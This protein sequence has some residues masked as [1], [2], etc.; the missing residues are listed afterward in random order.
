MRETPYEAAKRLFQA[1][2]PN[3]RTSEAILRP[4][5]NHWIECTEWFV[6]RVHDRGQIDEEMGSEE[7]KNRF[8]VFELALSA[9]VRGFF[10]TVGELDENLEEANS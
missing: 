1:I 5:I 3:N 9:L 4:R 10:E 7:L 6:Q 8:E 2:D